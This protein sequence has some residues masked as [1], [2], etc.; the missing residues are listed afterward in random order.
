LFCHTLSK[1]HAPRRTLQWHATY[2]YITLPIR[3]GGYYHHRDTLPVSRSALLISICH[4]SSGDFSF[5]SDQPLQLLSK[6]PGLALNMVGIYLKKPVF[7]H[8]QQRVALSRMVFRVSKNNVNVLIEGKDT[9]SPYTCSCTTN[10]VYP[11][12]LAWPVC[13]FE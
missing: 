13:F 11:E 5:L 10:V 9:T 6:S 3:L 7:A 8:D 12:I 2:M 1:P 4:S